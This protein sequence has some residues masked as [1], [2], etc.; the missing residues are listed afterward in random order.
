MRLVPEKPVVVDPVIPASRVGELMANIDNKNRQIDSL[1][2]QVKSF[3]DSN[4]QLAIEYNDLSAKYAALLS[5]HSAVSAAC[6]V[7]TLKLFKLM[8]PAPEVVEK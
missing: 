2:D 7:A 3:S 6:D 8:N 1:L 5:E 4:A